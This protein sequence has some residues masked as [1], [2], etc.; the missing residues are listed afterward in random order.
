MIQQG[1]VCKKCFSENTRVWD[2]RDGID[3]TNG[4]RF[5]RRKC[6]DC[7]NRWTTVELYY[8]DFEKLERDAKRGALNGKN[9]FG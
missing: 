4:R 2:I 8:E 3:C 5:R 7:G 6:L 9:Y 1:N